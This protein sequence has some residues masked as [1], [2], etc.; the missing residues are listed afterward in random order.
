M[1]FKN[2]PTSASDASEWARRYREP[3]ELAIRRWIKFAALDCLARD[4]SLCKTVILRGSLALSFYDPTN[5][6]GA[7]IDIY[8]T[9]L[10]EA[11]DEKIVA[12]LVEQLNSI[13]YKWLPT[14]FPDLGRWSSRIKSEIKIEVTRLEY[15]LQWNTL[16]LP[17]PS[18]RPMRVAVLECLIAEKLLALLHQAS[19]VS[20]GH[21]SKSRSKDV[22]DIY[23]VL[24]HTSHPINLKRIMF[25]F[26][27]RTPMQTEQ[28]VM[29]TASYDEF[30]R[31]LAEEQY[32]GQIHEKAAAIPFDR[33][34]A[35]I[36]ELV[37]ALSQVKT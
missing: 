32:N 16:R 37:R 28:Y 8:I 15:E 5:R 7:D 12:A 35:S 18:N 19:V 31:S 34:W 22:L 4:E 30:V 13:M 2:F 20:R 10:P 33:A 25:H 1:K 29:D 11:A 3:E 36:M 26:M 9:S 21:Q 17:S 24:K 23:H 14:H 27:A 6:L